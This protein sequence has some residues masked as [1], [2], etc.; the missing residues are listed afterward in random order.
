MKVLINSRGKCTANQPA[1]LQ[2]EWSDGVSHQSQDSFIYIDE[3]SWWRKPECQEKS[4]NHEA[5]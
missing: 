5:P 2:E 4:T 1:I 3:V